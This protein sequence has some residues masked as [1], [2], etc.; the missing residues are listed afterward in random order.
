MENEHSNARSNDP[1]EWKWTIVFWLPAVIILAGLEIA[2][3]ILQRIAKRPK[4]TVTARF[5]YIGEFTAARVVVIA[6]TAV[7][8]YHLFA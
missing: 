8:L 4:H 2:V 5:R 3:R 7:G 6:V 1:L